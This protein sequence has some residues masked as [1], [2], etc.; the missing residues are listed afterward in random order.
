M[1]P[2]ELIALGQ[3]LLIDISLAGDNAI[4]VGL[5][6]AGLPKEDRKKA[7]LIGILAATLLRIVFAFFAV[8]ML[9]ITGLLVA[10]GL[11]LLWVSWKMYREIRHSHQS[12]KS[13]TGHDKPLP[14]KLSA[15]IIQITL[16]DISMSLDNVLAVAG[17]ARDH[18]WVLVVGLAVSVL[19]MGVAS[20]YIVKLTDRYKWVA[21]LGLA[22][23]LYTSLHM[24]WDG[25]I[26]LMK[27][28][29]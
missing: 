9:Q 5:A 21:Y 3:I 11:L 29:G 25:T 6:A 24:M 27:K 14:K 16:A 12:S 10:G 2:H 20:T 1:D 18:F 15:A 26:D 19:L 7:V 13:S 17:V 22:I 4:A 8:Q 23:I 28:L